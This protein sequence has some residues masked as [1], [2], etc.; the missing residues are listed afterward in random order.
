MFSVE[1]YYLVLLLKSE[2]FLGQCQ[3]APSGPT[4]LPAGIFL[5]I[6]FE[7]TS[8]KQ[9]AAQPDLST[10]SKSPPSCLVD[11]HFVARCP[12]S[13]PPP[14]NCQ[15]EEQELE[16]LKLE[17]KVVFCGGAVSKRSKV[18]GESRREDFL[19][20]NLERKVGGDW[21]TGQPTSDI[22]LTTLPPL[23]YVKSPNFRSM[24]GL[25]KV[26]HQQL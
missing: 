22:I 4:V 25:G 1:G 16:N 19:G 9:E 11:H 17:E 6:L 26:V 15:T 23:L 24:S 20:E 8:R 13:W 14:E 21:K 5:G 3:I 10:I 18:R 12:F 7:L 2:P